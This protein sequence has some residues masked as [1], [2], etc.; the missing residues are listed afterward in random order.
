MRARVDSTAVAAPLERCL[1]VPALEP[2]RAVASLKMSAPRCDRARD[3][4]PTRPNSD[5]RRFISAASGGWSESKTSVPVTDS[6]TPVSLTH[7]TFSPA[8]DLRTRPS[9]LS[10]NFVIIFWDPIRIF[11]IRGTYGRIYVRTSRAGKAPPR[12]SVIGLFHGGFSPGERASPRV[13]SELARGARTDLPRTRTRRARGDVRT[14]AGDSGPRSADS[15]GARSVGRRRL[16]GKAH[17]RFLALNL[18]SREARF[19]PVHRGRAG[20]PWVAP[21]ATPLA[22]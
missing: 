4:D 9:P 6:H 11:A 3:R 14:G 18:L 22:A 8:S 20:G 15:G 2:T 1:R 5:H 10:T 16:T 19:L 17:L 21:G 12:A 13:L 7:D